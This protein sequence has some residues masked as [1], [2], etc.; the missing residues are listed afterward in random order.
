MQVGA[1]YYT[2]YETEPV[3]HWDGGVWR[4]PLLGRYSSADP[5]VAAQHVEWAADFGIDV[6]A[7]NWSGP[8]HAEEALRSGLLA[9]PN[10][11][12]IRYCLFYDVA[13]RFAALGHID[14]FHLPFS[15]PALR[16]AFVQDLPRLAAEHFGHPSYFRIRGKP[17]LWLYLTRNYEGDWAGALAEA[18]R[19]IGQPFY[20]VADE[21]WHAEPRSERLAA[22]EALSTYNLY[23]TNRLA[24]RPSW[25]L[26]EFNELVFPVL[27]RWQAA[28]LPAPVQPAVLPEYD[29]RAVPRRSHHPPVVAASREEVLQTF[30]RARDLALRIADPEQRI[31]WVTSF[32]EW[33]EGTAVEPTEPGGPAFPNGHPGFELLEALREA[34]EP[35]AVLR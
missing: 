8:G 30:L 7:V 22:F 14:P 6:L 34:F 35:G 25:S 2:W 21:V 32:N 15:R 4:E 28:A 29:D 19:R 12:R 27:E 3:R 5:Q 24:G 17:V 13:N 9:A 11:G 16:E 26:P 18:R 33:H 1:H 20:V 23:D 10:L 31:V